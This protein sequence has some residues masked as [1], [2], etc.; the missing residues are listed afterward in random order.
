MN[1]VLPEGQEFE[2]YLCP[3][4]NEMRTRFRFAA[5]CVYVT[6]P[7]YLNAAFLMLNLLYVLEGG[8]ERNPNNLKLIDYY[9]LCNR[10]KVVAKLPNDFRGTFRLGAHMCVYEAPSARQHMYKLLVPYTSQDGADVFGYHTY[11]VFQQRLRRTELEQGEQL[12]NFLAYCS[13]SEF[14]KFPRFRSP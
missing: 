12:L 14:G 10:V 13:G 1:P 7:I 8:V 9:A 6:S 3:R 4:I 11:L 5:T 2:S